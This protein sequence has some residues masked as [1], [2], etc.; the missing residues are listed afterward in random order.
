LATW[1]ASQSVPP[2]TGVVGPGVVDPSALTVPVRLWNQGS[3]LCLATYWSLAWAPVKLVTPG[4]SGC[5]A[6]A[7]TNVGLVVGLFAAVPGPPQTASSRPGETLGQVMGDF[8]QDLVDVEPSEPIG[9]HGGH[10][11]PPEGVGAPW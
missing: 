8:D 6:D 7:L 1:F 4:G 5:A 9:R 10:V 11:R 3:G 2:P